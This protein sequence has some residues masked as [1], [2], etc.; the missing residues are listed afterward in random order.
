ML[1]VGLG[2]A[3]IR[4]ALE[5][6]AKVGAW[7]IELEVFAANTSA[8]PLYEKFEFNMTGATS[9]KMIRRSRYV[10]SV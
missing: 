7:A 2:D 5:E 9:R 10:D 6:V 3:V 1:D 8:R 4:R